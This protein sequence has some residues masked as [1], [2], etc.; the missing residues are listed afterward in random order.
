[1]TKGA[2]ILLI[3]PGSTPGTP[4]PEIASDPGR[5]MPIGLL[6]LAASLE[7]DGFIVHLLDARIVSKRDTSHWIHEKL[8]QRPLFAGISAMTVQLGH[9]LAIAEQIRAESPDTPIVWGGAHP[10]LFPGSTARDPLADV[11]AKS[12]ADISAVLLAHALCDGEPEIKDINGLY[13]VPKDGDGRVIG[14]DAPLI[15]V[16]QLPS[17][18]YHLLDMEH[19]L[20]RRIPDGSSVNGVDVL[21]S[22]GCPYRCAFCPNELLLGRRWRKRPVEQVME[23]LDLLLSDGNVNHVWFMDD[24]FIG[25][26]PRVVAILERLHGSYPHVRWEANVRADMF[27]NGLVDRSFL[28]FLKETGCAALRMG[29]ESGNDEI[30]LR[31]KKDITVEQTVNAV[32]ACSESGITPVCFFMMGIPGETHDQIFDTVQLMADLKKRFPETVVC[33]P[34]LFRPYPGGELYGDALKSGLSEPTS[35]NE[36]AHE[37]GKQGYLSS[38]RLPWLSDP[39]LMEDI[40]FYTFHIEQFDHLSGY[41]YPGLR[42]IL[43]KVAFWRARHKKWQFRMAAWGR[44]LAARRRAG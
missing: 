8:P 16:S 13:H 38:A 40:L 12:E 6:S 7:A 43:A 21:T 10:S 17:P 24:L 2:S 3:Y 18:A 25:D 4:G 32:A 44:R 39:I 1:M 36:W 14:C 28:A 15:D 41:G 22:R 23:E 11:V 33:G 9:G 5:S 26:K 20:A 42:H 34:G 27:R 37:L 31:L 30:L 19:Y 35:M 29:A